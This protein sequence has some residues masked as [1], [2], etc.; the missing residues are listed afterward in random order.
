MSLLPTDEVSDAF[1]NDNMDDVLTTAGCVEF[2]DYVNE[3]YISEEASFPSYMWAAAPDISVRTTNGP[4]SFH[5]H[6]NSQFFYSA[7]PNI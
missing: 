7:H 5:G 1:T 6:L 2:S 4:E 3:Q